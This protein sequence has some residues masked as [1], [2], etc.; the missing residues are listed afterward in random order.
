[1]SCR[2]TLLGPLQRLAMKRLHR[3]ILTACMCSVSLQCS[4]LRGALQERCS[5]CPQPAR[6]SRY[7]SK[8]RIVNTLSLHPTCPVFIALGSPEPAQQ[9]T[10]NFSD[11]SAAVSAQASGGSFQDSEAEIRLQPE[12]SCLNPIPLVL[13]QAIILHDLPLHCTRICG[14]AMNVS[15][16]QDSLVRYMLRAVASV[17][18]MSYVY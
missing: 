4:P 16:W 7:S 9:G 12:P 13:Q 6:T 8:A 14:R 5:S 11:L 10:W 2:S 1:M 15:C 17:F 18:P 3:E